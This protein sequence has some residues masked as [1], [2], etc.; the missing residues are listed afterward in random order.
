MVPK[1]VGSHLGIRRDKS[2]ISAQNNEALSIKQEIWRDKGEIKRDKARY[3]YSYFEKS[4][5]YS[6]KLRK[7]IK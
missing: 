1:K 6:N 2:E 3:K 5:L 4:R 7:K